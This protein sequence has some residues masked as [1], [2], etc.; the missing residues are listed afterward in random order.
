MPSMEE[1]KK[2]LMTEMTDEDLQDF[3]EF[4]DWAD[5]LFLTVR[6]QLREA[7]GKLENIKDKSDKNIQ[8]EIENI[9]FLL[10]TVALALF[11]YTEYG[12]PK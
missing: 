7:I 10:R 2:N 8:K 4:Q 9:L 5:R 3:K 11:M 6:S 1:I 12:E